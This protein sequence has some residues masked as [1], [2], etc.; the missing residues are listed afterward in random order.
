MPKKTKKVKRYPHKL[1][2]NYPSNSLYN[3]ELFSDKKLR[4]RQNTA[5]RIIEDHIT[6]YDMFWATND[7][8]NYGNEKKDNIFKTEEKLNGLNKLFV[9]GMVTN[10]ADQ[11]NLLE[12]AYNIIEETRGTC[13]TIKVRSE[14]VEI[15]MRQ[16]VLHL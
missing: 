15:A 11:D 6:L 7:F 12:V 2:E 16:R 8:V 1:A 14:M 4:I 13:L 3:W 9:F 10:D 5:L